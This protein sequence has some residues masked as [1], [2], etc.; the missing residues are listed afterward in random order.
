MI[1]KV[2][3]AVARG[4]PLE[5]PA[6]TLFEGLDLLKRSPRN[7]HKAHIAVRQVQTGAVERVG[8][9]RAVQTP[10]VVIGTEHKVIDDEL[11]V[12]PKEIGKRLLAAWPVEDV[13]LFHLL[14]GERAPKLSKFLPLPRE[15]LLLR[16]QGYARG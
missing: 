16:Q 4:E 9:E 10:L 11:A 14:P 6:H 2:E 13:V 1:V 15:F 7:S 3:I 5:A 8:P 12:F